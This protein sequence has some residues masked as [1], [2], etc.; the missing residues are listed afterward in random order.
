M[1]KGASV[2]ILRV[3]VVVEIDATLLVVM[4]GLYY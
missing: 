1:G 4:D 3:A 2:N